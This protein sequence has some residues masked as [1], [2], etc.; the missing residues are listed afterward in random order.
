V[1]KAMERADIRWAFSQEHLYVTVCPPDDGDPAE[2]DPEAYNYWAGIFNREGLDS[3]H[4]LK[5]GKKE[6]FRMTS[7]LPGMVKP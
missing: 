2:F 4:I 6:N 5:F 3:A 1:G 7:V